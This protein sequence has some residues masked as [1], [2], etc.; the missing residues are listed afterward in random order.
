M[1]GKRKD[2]FIVG[3]S[4]RAELGFNFGNCGFEGGFK[5]SVVAVGVFE[6]FNVVVLAAK[7]EVLTGLGG[8]FQVEVRH[9]FEVV[10][11]GGF[12]FVTFGEF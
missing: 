2:C 3:R 7:G 5:E 4:F 8:V 9:A 12:G 6:D 10:G 1:G 11:H